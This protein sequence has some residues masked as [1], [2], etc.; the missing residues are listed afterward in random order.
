VDLAIPARDKIDDAEHNQ[1]G[2]W[3]TSLRG[4][5]R[6]PAS[7]RPQAARTPQDQQYQG[8]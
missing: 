7:D 3:A 1:G 8:R 5:V 6:I 4:A 2:H